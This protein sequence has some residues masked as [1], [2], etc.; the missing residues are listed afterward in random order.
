MT[1]R[2]MCTVNCNSMVSLRPEVCSDSVYDV[3]DTPCGVSFFAFFR[4]FSFAYYY[5]Y[6]AFRL[7]IQR[8]TAKTCRLQKNGAISMAA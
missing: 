8:S 1:E 2:V 4:F 7:F 3:I 5:P 6:Y